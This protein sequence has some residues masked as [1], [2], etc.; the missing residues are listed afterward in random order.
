MISMRE[1]HEQFVERHDF[2]YADSDFL[3]NKY[4][5]ILFKDIPEA[6]VCCIDEHLFAVNE[7][8]KVV[9]I[10]QIYGFP[11]IQYENNICDRDFDIV[12][13][14]ERS[15]L[16]MDIDLHKQLEAEEHAIILN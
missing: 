12:Q 15:L 16:C 11:V 7:L 9:S 8:L 10:S 5:H 6:W 1:F 2:E 13:N 14:L 4:Q 3:Q